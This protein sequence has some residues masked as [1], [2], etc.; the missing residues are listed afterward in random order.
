MLIGVILSSG[1]TWDYE[2]WEADGV[3]LDEFDDFLDGEPDW[4]EV[5]RN[6]EKYATKMRD[7]YLCPLN[8]VDAIFWI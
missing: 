3:T 2:I 7:R 8:D 1:S 4:N 5:Y 6:M